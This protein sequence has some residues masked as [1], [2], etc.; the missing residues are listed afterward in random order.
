MFKHNALQICISLPSGILKTE[1]A[2]TP[3]TVLNLRQKKGPVGRNE[4]EARGE[5]I[6]KKG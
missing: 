4:K 5:I 6:A 2:S 1:T 3:T